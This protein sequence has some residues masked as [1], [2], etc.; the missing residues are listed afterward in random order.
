MGMIAPVKR[1]VTRGA[2][3]LTPVPG[4]CDTGALPAMETSLLQ[5]AAV[6]LGI[7][8]LIVI[9]AALVRRLSGWQGVPG[10]VVLLGGVAVGTRERVVLLEVAGTRI[11]VGVTPGR[12]EALHVLQPPQK[13]GLA[14]EGVVLREGEEGRC[15]SG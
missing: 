4:A 1:W 11:L 12:V 9:G 5:V 14:T 15:G 13:A 7:L 8:G 3:T 6:L 2:M 10:A